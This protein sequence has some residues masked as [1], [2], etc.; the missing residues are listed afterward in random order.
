M[1]DDDV[2]F[3]ALKA[4]AIQATLFNTAQVYARRKIASQTCYGG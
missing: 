1:G 2:R 4:K 3:P